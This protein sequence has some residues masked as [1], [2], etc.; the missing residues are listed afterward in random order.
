MNKLLP[1][2]SLFL[3]LPA[4][5][6]DNPPNDAEKELIKKE[7]ITMLQQ[8]HEAIKSGGLT[9][10]FDYLDESKEFFWVPPG[11]QSALS[12]DSVRAIIK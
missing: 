2:L 7:V 3:L 11:Y 10:E 4:C 8:Y 6:R 5:Y 12:Y 1:L 9:A